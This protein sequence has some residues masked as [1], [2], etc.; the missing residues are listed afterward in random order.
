M[1]GERERERE[2]RRVVFGTGFGIVFA[3]DVTSVCGGD[4]S[5][6]SL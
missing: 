1:V 4:W 2:Q 3:I 5:F 6:C